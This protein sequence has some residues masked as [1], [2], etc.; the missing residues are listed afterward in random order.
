MKRHDPPENTP[1]VIA[2]ALAFFGATALLA[3]SSGVFS[4]LSGEELAALGLF[5]VAFALLT[6]L[7]DRGVRSAVNGAIAALRGRSSRPDRT[8]GRPAHIRT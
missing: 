5:G 4:L 7:Q 3:W 1:R 2:T 6:Y 8:R